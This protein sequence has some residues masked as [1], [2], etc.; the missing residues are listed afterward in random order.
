MM[1]REED[2]PLLR[3]EGLSKWYGNQLGC[4]DVSFAVHPGE[5]MAVVG[6]SGSGKTTLLRLLS[7]Q[8]APSAGRVFYRMRDG[9]TRD[10]V[11]LGEAERRFL[12]RTDWGYVHQDPALGL[13]MAV[14]GHLAYLACGAQGLQI[15]CLDSPRLSAELLGSQVLLQWPASATNWMLESAPSL[16]AQQWQTVPATPQ[17]INDS[18]QLL[19]PATHPSAFFRLSAQ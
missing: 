13:R 10:L 2:Q 14:S 12:F 9:T 8:L 17:R 4:R 19:I 18:Y 16:P 11:S 5:V 1:E 3:A 6:E 7:T 15:Y